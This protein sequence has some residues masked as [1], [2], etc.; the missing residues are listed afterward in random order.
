[1]K[2]LRV[3]EIN[4]LP[5]KFIDDRPQLLHHFPI[6]SPKLVPSLSLFTPTIL[7]QR[8][9]ADIRINLRLLEIDGVP[10]AA[11]SGVARLEDLMPFP[12][13]LATITIIDSGNESSGSWSIVMGQTPPF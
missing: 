10:Q 1:L 12:A 11:C 6:L 2:T 3:D 9:R 4:P 5:V 13:Q 7:I 8:A